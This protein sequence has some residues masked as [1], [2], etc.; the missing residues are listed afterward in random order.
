MLPMTAAHSALLIIDVQYLDA[1]PDYGTLAH[2]RELGLSDSYTYYTE[3]LQDLV[4]PNIQR[5]QASFRQHGMEVV[6]VHIESLTTSGRERG[7]LYRTLAIGAPRG[8]REAEI[9]PEVAPVGDELV[10]AKTS[11]SPFNSTNID[12]MLRNLGIEQL[13]LV[14]VMTSGCVESTARDAA[15]RG[16]DVILVTDACAAR[17]PEMEQKTHEAI[18]GTFVHLLT[19]DE[20][21]DLVGDVAHGGDTNE[22]GARQT[23][24]AR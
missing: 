11:S 3:R 18:G 15:D 17:T 22:K 4:I 10:I 23:A 8:S 1:H 14:G 20:V 21:L 12:V 13:V 24:L 9:L 16:Y 2:A 19:T 7:W 5:L 6:H